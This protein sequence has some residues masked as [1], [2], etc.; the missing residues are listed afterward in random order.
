MKSVFSI[1]ILVIF[2]VSCKNADKK[3]ELEG[4]KKQYEE[5]SEKIKTLE[6]E[7][8]KTDSNVVQNSKFVQVNEVKTQKFEHYIEVQGKVDGDKNVAVNAQ[9]MGV[10]SD[11]F[12]KEGDEVSEGQVLAQIDASVLEQGIKELEASMSFVDTLYQKQKR[13]W[14]QKIGSEVQYLTAK[15]N[16]ESLEKKRKTLLEQFEMSK[17]KSPIS[18][19]IEEIP[20]KIGQSIAPGFPAFRIVNF[21]TVKV[22]ADVAESYSSKIKKGNNVNIFFPDF[23]EELSAN[24]D[25]ASKYISPIN[26]TFQVEVRLTETKDIDFRANM[27][28]VIKIND[29]RSDSAVVVPINLVQ[30]SMNSTYVFLAYNDGNNIIAKKC[31]VEIGFIYNGLAEIK[32][33]LKAGDKI[34]TSGYQDL[35]EGQVVSY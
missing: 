11:I 31:D 9:S 10:I 2:F 30:K 22:Y 28:A 24:I 1:I 7:I 32:K 26:R 12:V 8:A 16:K 21:S 18:G 25:F 4:L 34:I 29:Y 5:L 23:N 19:T 33:G 6:E 14:E 13:L 20:I 17:I 35:M 27:I 3:V 15:N